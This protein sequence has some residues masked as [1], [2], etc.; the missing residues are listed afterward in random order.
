MI[1]DILIILAFL[2][3]VLRGI[4]RG[5][6]QTVIGLCSYVVSLI[7]SVIFFDMIKGMLYGFAPVAGKIEQFRLSIEKSVEGYFAEGISELPA[8]LKSRVGDFGGDFATEI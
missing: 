8:F 2:F 4:K 1:V 6:A 7:L 3:C 5:F